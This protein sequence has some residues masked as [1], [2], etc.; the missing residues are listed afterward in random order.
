MQPT[1]IILEVRQWN[2]FLLFSSTLMYGNIWPP[3]KEALDEWF[4]S[5][6]AGIWGGLY[7]READIYVCVMQGWG[8]LKL[9]SL[10]SPL[11]QIWIYKK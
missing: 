4:I 7:A 3:A 8:L 10:V 9:R 1:N 6:T 2:G 5:N 11:W